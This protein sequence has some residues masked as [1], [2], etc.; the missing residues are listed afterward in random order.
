MAL[1]AQAVFGLK[2]LLESPRPADCLKAAPSSLVITVRDYSGDIEDAAA[3]GLISS[4]WRLSL[5]LA[6]AAW[7]AWIAFGRL[8]LAVHSPADLLGGCVLGYAV[9][10]LWQQLEQPYNA[11]LAHSPLLTLHVAALSFLVM[12]CSPMASRATAAYGYCTAWLGGWAG[13]VLGHRVVH[14]VAAAAAA[15]AGG[16][17]VNVGLKVAARTM[18][19]QQQL[20]A[21]PLWAA[22]AVMAAKMVLG[23][24]VVAAA[25]VVVKEGMLLLLPHVFGL[26]P[27]CVR[28]LWQP[29]VAGVAKGSS[30]SSS[31]SSSD[32]DGSRSGSS[33]WT[34]S[35]SDV[36]IQH[37]MYHEVGLGSSSGCSLWVLRHAADG[38]ANDV[39]VTARFAAYVAVGFAVAT[40]DAVWQPLVA[41][42][43]YASSTA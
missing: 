35:S 36:G 31:S 39:A 6:A 28:C 13:V 1:Q 3:A 25:K 38:T 2:D 15:A 12:R 8:Y 23:L 7:V 19:L 9:L 16:P 20:G 34:A 41:N 37:G 32:A 17:G 5:Q 27:T 11:W 18:G 21:L 42:Y 10:Q 24:A 40:F 22:V 26:V 29:P 14:P 4:G 30:S 43:M 33:R